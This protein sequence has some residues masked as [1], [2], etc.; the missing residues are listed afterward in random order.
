MQRE[1]A[2]NLVKE[3]ENKTLLT[4]TR[5]KVDVVVSKG[6]DNIPTEIIEEDLMTEV[7]EEIETEE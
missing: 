5:M 6:E 3:S 1:K 4:G 7:G 2:T